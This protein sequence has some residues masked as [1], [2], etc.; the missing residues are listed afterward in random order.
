MMIT[1]EM[2]R[3]MTQ[4]SSST[5][6]DALSSS[7]GSAPSPWFKEGL[8]FHC[9]GCGA[10]CTGSGRVWLSE[11]E[12]IEMA[13]LMMLEV[14]RFVDS[15]VER[16]EGRWALREDPTRGDCCFLKEGRCSVYYARPRQ[17]RTFPWWP[18]TLESPERWREAQRLCEGIEHSDAPLV[19][20]EEITATLTEERRGRARRSR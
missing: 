14:D 3:E 11:A 5:W 9:T 4:E 20:I 1:R 6:S 19:S 17:C 8:K 16:V 2:T 13:R 7:L 10:C 15:Y 12:L 18:T